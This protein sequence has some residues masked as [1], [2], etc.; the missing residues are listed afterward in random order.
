MGVSP[1]TGYQALP[2]NTC[3]AGLFRG[4]LRCRAAAMP[5]HRP[6]KRG[7]LHI[8]HAKKLPAAGSGF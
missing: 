1:A 3:G 8:P 7:A 4:P 5:A 2:D 6:A